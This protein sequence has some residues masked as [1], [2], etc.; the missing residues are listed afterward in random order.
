MQDYTFKQM[1]EERGMFVVNRDHVWVAEKNNPRLWMCLCIVP[2]NINMARSIQ[3]WHR[4]R[5]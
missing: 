5:K 2:L 3:L 4:G 1:L